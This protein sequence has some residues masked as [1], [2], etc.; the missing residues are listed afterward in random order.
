MRIALCLAA[1]VVA[2][3]AACSSSGITAGKRPGTANGIGQVVAPATTGKPVKSADFGNPITQGSLT[4]T[5]AGPVTTER[6]DSGLLAT[7]H[8]TMTNTAT[9]GDVVGP[10]FFGV[11]C[12]VNRDDYNPG[13]EMSTSTVG[14]DKHIAAG[15]TVTGIAVDAWL[16]WNSIAQCTGPTTVEA[17]FL[18]GGF[19]AWT[20]PVDV[21]AQVNKAG[22]S[23]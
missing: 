16:K 3:L 13:D 11:R 17:R 19:L 21:V 23:A 6:D 20:L 12:D 15:Q 22:G 18:Q 2:D 10:D 14:G 8:V 4:I 9:S 5:V 7:F 1:L